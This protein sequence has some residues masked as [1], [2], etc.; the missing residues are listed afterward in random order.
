MEAITKSAK[1]QGAFVGWNLAHVLVMFAL[2]LQ[3]M[4]SWLGGLVQ[5]YN[6]WN[7]GT[8]NAAGIFCTSS[9]ILTGAIIPRLKL[10]GEQRKT[11][12]FLMKARVLNPWK[13]PDAWQVSIS[14][15][16]FHWLLYL[17]SLELFAE[18]G[19]E[20]LIAKR[21]LIV[22]IWVILTEIR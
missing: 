21:K 7:S 4:G 6:I 14:L 19:M 10:G 17:A 12:R 8:G 5:L 3:W 11:L 20:V 2:N 13:M 22:L 1:S 18:V 15:Q 9:N 16:C